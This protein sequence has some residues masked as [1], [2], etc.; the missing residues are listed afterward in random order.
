MRSNIATAL[1][2]SSRFGWRV[3]PAKPADKS[4]Y[5]NGWQQRAT[6]DADE[7]ERLFDLFPD[8]MIGLP[9]GPINGLTVLDLD[10]KNGVDGVQSFRSL[11]LPCSTRAVVETPSGG[12]HLYLRTWD[13]VLPSPVG[14]LPGMDIRSSGAY[15]IAPGSVS[16]VGAYNWVDVDPIEPQDITRL[17][18]VLENFIQNPP[19][20]QFGK[21][22]RRAPRVDLLAPIYEGNRDCEMTRRCGF[23]FRKGYAECEVEAM[24][25]EIN[26]QCVHPP[27]PD[28]DIQRICRS[29][30]KREARHGRI[31]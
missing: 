23:L 1:E 17:C 22:Q 26:T 28:R 27:L 6:A 16:N 7:I 4:P 29:I 19:T 10:L 18:G 30:A 11:A 13:T 31:A 21:G 9:T 14:I 20:R 24:L 25:L 12:F 5:I 3:F 15:V 2:L 8:A